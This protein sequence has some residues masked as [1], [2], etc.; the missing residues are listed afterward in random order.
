[1]K[2]ALILGGTRGLGLSLAWEGY[3]RQVRPIITGRS[4]DLQTLAS[5][6]PSYAFFKLDLSNP[7][8]VEQ[9]GRRKAEPIDYLFWVAGNF[10]RGPFDQ[11]SPE[12]LESMIATHLSGPVRALELFQLGLHYILNRP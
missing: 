12:I 11:T 7:E 4:A 10:Y 3:T 6:P 2:Q 9:I 5:F 1:M 8:S